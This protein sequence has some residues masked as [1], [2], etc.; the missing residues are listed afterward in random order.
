MQKLPED[1]TRELR[2]L[3][4][5]ET[6]AGAVCAEEETFHPAGDVV[7][8]E[9]FL[10]GA[11]S[12][13]VLEEYRQHL[14]ECRRCREQMVVY[15]RA[16]VLSVPGTEVPKSVPAP[17]RKGRRVTVAVV[18]LTAA[19][20][21]FCMIPDRTSKIVSIPASPKQSVAMLHL[22]HLLTPE[23]RFHDECITSLGCLPNGFQ[24]GKA[25]PEWDEGHFPKVER[26][27]EEALKEEPQNE[28]LRLDYV[29]FLLFREQDFAKAERV[30]REHRGDSTRFHRL[31]GLL[32]FMRNDY[33][34]ATGHFSTVWVRDADKPNYGDCIN[35][36][37]SL[38]NVGE[39]EKACEL[40]RKAV[41]MTDDPTQ[42][43]QLEYILKN[44]RERGEP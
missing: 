4:R 43:K 40:Y 25:F 10:A 16:G 28:A 29:S 17:R 39:Q 13:E 37:A 14:A 21:V 19:T 23:D 22:E 12:E 11:L 26:A 32:A 27:F 24:P 8:M 42:K 31:A 35:L 44:I 34:A 6:T 41:S 36:A 7:F 33:D 1:V 20:L 15:A 5:Q 38:L 2:L 30:L 3:L 18:A 9:H